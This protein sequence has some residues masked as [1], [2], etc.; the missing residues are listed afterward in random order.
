[1]GVV[2]RKLA[3]GDKVLTRDDHVATVVT[4]VKEDGVL[5]A[6]ITYDDGFAP[7]EVSGRVAGTEDSPIW[8]HRVKTG[9]VVRSGGDYWNQDEWVQEKGLREVV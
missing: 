5:F 7:F 1:M 6:W 8:E 3:R 2:K 4:T 9:K